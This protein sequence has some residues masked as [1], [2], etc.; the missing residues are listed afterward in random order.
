MA[1]NEDL[2]IDPEVKSLVL[3]TTQVVL[4]A[5]TAKTIARMIEGMKYI[6]ESSISDSDDERE[7]VL[8]SQLKTHVRNSFPVNAQ[9][10][11]PDD[12][13]GPSGLS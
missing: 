10:R 1:D 9:D 12:S 11:E 6:Y 13:L 4:L 2:W 3:T 7:L 8:P 5:R